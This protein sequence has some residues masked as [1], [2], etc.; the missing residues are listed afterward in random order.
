MIYVKNFNT[1]HK[2]CRDLLTGMYGISTCID[3]GMDGFVFD[4]K[5]PLFNTPDEAEKYLRDNYEE[6]E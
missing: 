2:V 1:Y 5:F 6:V 4:G 3:P